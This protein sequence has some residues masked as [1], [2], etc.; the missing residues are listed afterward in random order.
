MRIAFMDSGIG[1]ITVLHE[2]LRQLPYE[3][4]IYY[5]DTKH[6]PYGTKPKELV[7]QSIFEAVTELHD[8]GIKALVIAC[9]TATSI[10]VSELRASF[11][12]PIIGMEPAVKPAVER[13]QSLHKRV[14][15]T[16]TPLTLRE[17]K[18]QDLVAKTDNESI[19]DSLPL[20][21]LVTLCE[22]FEFREEAVL[23][24]L[25]EMLLP[26]RMEEYGSVV[27]GCTHFPFFRRH[28]RKLLPLHVELIDGSGGT[29]KR[30]RQVLEQHGL[31]SR[32]GTGDVR[33]MSSKAEPGEL[34]RIRQAHLLLNETF[35]ENDN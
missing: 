9:N 29:I 21:E 11:P 33:Y 8:Q 5:A 19:V 15:V 2:A 18:Y 31:L 17:T 10:A 32:S 14:L 4:Y 22:Q 6:V 24:Y 30:L 34:E 20:P 25:R 1:G 26:Y 3:D 23:P 7:K 13:V 16:A 27:L 35:N 12:F 28:F